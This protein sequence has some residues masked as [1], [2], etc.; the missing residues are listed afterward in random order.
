MTNRLLTGQESAVLALPADTPMPTAIACSNIAFIKYWGNRHEALRLP[1][2]PSLS[3]NLHGLETRAEVVF[4]PALSAD[5]I[6]INGQPATGPAA[7]R[8]SAHLDVI[9]A[10]AGLTARAR[11]RSANNFPAG[12]GIASSASAFAALSVAGAAAAGLSLTEAELSA[13]A[14]RGSGSAC[15]SV[16]GGFTVWRMGEHASGEDSFA[17][18]LAPADHWALADVVALISTAHKKTGSTE[19]HALAASSPLQAG[20]VAGAAQRLDICAN[21]IRAR[22]FAALA[23]VVEADST[24]MHAVM[25]TSQPPLFYWQPLTLAVMQAVRDWRAHGLPVCFTI[26]AGANVHCLCEAT[27]AGQVQAGLQS[28]GIGETLYATPGGPARLIES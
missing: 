13:L 22:D 14:R 24:L 1:V 8:V 23:E 5:E 3:M 21:A 2:N 15:R 10:R 11:V 20:R 18:T 17:A 6:I 7:D 26:D 27:A 16:P 25:M 4:D 19:G 28:L 9:R 12:A